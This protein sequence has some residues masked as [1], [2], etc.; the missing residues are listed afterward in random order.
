M[1]MQSGTVF[2][3]HL[4]VVSSESCLDAVVET[5][6]NLPVRRYNFEG[7]LTEFAAGNRVHSKLPQVNIRSISERNKSSARNKSNFTHVG[8]L[9]EIGITQ[10][11]HCGVPPHQL[12]NCSSRGKEYE[13]KCGE[14]HGKSIFALEDR[15]YKEAHS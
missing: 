4:A 6:D 2:P 12:T 15:F 5:R 11:V 1:G 8:T 13:E 14:L 3:S 9:Q 10:V 7:T